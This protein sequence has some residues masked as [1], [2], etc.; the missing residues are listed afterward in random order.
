MRWTMNS[1]TL[2]NEKTGNKDAPAPRRPRC[3]GIA[4]KTGLCLLLLILCFVFRAPVLTGLARLWIVNDPPAKADAILVLGGGL[5]YRP[6]VAASFYTNGLAPKI[7]MAQPKLSPTAEMGLTV[8]EYQI[9]HNVLLRLGV[10]ANAIEMIGT[11]V[12]S[13]REEALAVR[14][15]ADQNRA[16]SVLIPTD[17]FHTRRVR[18]MFH[19]ALRGS[20]TEVRIVA[21]ELPRYNAS[22]WWQHEEGLITFENEVIKS[23]Y[24]WLKY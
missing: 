10:P 8:P 23:L 3:W 11:N 17:L 4:R 15:W 14:Q 1:T 16:R 21:V 20:T 6:F 18:R 22:N 5:E 9:A 7:L 19:R 13:T 12:S 24:Y 2:S